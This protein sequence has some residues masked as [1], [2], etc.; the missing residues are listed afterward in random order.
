MYTGPVTNHPKQR[1]CL[2]YSN[3]TPYAY[4]VVTFRVS[5]AQIDTEK[6]TYTHTYTRKVHTHDRRLLSKRCL[7]SGLAADASQ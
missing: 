3:I 1:A 4:S 5:L 7:Q 2:I 6:H